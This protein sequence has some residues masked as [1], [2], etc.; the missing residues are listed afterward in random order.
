MYHAVL[1]LK[2]CVCVGRGDKLLFDQNAMYFCFKLITN[3]ISLIQYTCIDHVMIC[4]TYR[5]FKWNANCLSCEDVSYQ[6]VSWF[7]LIRVN[8]IF[9]DGNAN[10]LIYLKL[11]KQIYASVKNIA[12]IVFW[13]EKRATDEIENHM[14]TH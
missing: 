5:L 8:T 4:E 7:V 3:I 14:Q 13:F 1:F 9:I 10:V 6:T 12:K 11:M 2:T